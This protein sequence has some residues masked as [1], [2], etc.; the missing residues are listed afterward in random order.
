MRVIV[1]GGGGREHAIIKKLKENKSIEQIFA[2]PGNGGMAEDATCVNIGAKDIDAIV[3]FACEKGID[4]AVSRGRKD[5]VQLLLD[6]G[7][8][9]NLG[10]ASAAFRGSA[11][12]VQ[13]L[14]GKGADA[15]E[16]FRAAA[17]G[18]WKD[19]MLLALDKGA[20][21]NAALASAAY[22]G[23]TDIVAQYDMDENSY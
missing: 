6:K 15:T 23:Y 9:P 19:I 18:R 5:M 7:A 1:V 14:L 13:F 4:Y 16:A 12:I 11:D 2:L 21:P 17:E 3:S 8:D 22:W 20:D 10:I